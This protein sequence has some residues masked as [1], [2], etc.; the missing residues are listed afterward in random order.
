MTEEELKGR[1]IARGFTFENLTKNRALITALKEEL[2]NELKEELRVTL[3][4]GFS[5]VRLGD[6]IETIKTA[7]LIRM[8]VN[9]LK[10]YINR[11]HVKKP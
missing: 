1:L 2:D 10:D 7:Y 6:K 4:R 9:D 3:Q 11:P 8:T 5:V